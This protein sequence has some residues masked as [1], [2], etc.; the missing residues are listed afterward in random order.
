MQLQDLLDACTPGGA[1]VLTSVTELSAAAGPH[2]SVTP[3]KFKDGNTPC[4]GYEPRF[5]DGAPA[6]SVIIDTVPSSV[7]RGEQAISQAIKLSLIHI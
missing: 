6:E 3:T 7:N 1:S 4:F 5:I 2:A